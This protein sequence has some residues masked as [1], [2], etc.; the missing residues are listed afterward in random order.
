MGWTP[1]KTKSSIGKKFIWFIQL[2]FKVL[3]LLVLFWY[4]PYSS[5]T[6]FFICIYTILVVGYF[7]KLQ[8]QWSLSLFCFRIYI[9]QSSTVHLS[10]HLLALLI[11]TNSQY[12]YENLHNFHNTPYQKALCDVLKKDE[13]WPQQMI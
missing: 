11:F 5:N 10:S 7:F 8:A 9:C 12:F 4:F 3:T 13:R 6:S 1:T 2:H